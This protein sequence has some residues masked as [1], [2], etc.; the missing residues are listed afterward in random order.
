MEGL[1]LRWQPF[2]ADAQ[3]HEHKGSGPGGGQF[4]PKGGGGSLEPPDHSDSVD[5]IKDKLP[6]VDPTTWEKV[7]HFTAKTHA[8]V[9]SWMVRA[10]PTIMKLMPDV[11][12]NSE[13]FQK[14]GF[15]PGLS[16]TAGPRTH[17]AIFDATGIGTHMMATI[18]SHVLAKGFVWAKHKFAGQTN[19]SDDDILEAAHWLSGLLA[20]IAK[21]T[22]LSLVT[23]PET[24][25]SILATHK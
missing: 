10:T 20:D 1:P 14:L 25:A 6:A 9:Y 23:D 7:R 11:I 3:G 17:D 19:A 24:I 22:G 18:A 4:A 16:G 5:G 13:D 2:A 12:E 15:N 21:E 8:A